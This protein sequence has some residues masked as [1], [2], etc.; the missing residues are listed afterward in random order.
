[1]SS[2]IRFVFFLYLI[3]CP[4][5]TAFAVNRVKIPHQD[6]VD[7]TTRIR[8]ILANNKR[9]NIVL[10]FEE[11]VYH[12]YPEK[13]EGLYICVSNNDNG[14][15]RVAFNLS[16][17]ENVRIEGAGTEFMFHG[18]MVPFYINEAR[19][20]SISGIDMDYD[21]SFIFEGEVIANDPVKKTFDIRVSND[22]HHS[23]RGKRLFLVVMTGNCLPV[24]ILFLTPK[25]VLP[26]TAPKNI[27]MHIGV[28][29]CWPRL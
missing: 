21:Y 13:A 16:G 24:K 11:G 25:H 7:F 26:I 15:K 28:T 6:N 23:I 4:G 18:S 10:E 2:Y 9:G 17:M 12:F 8:E 29:N 22:I 5:T 27:I 1:M 20:I 14:Y 3:I 19:N